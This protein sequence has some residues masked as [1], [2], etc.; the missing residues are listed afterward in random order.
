MEFLIAASLS[1]GHTGPVNN[2]LDMYR[3]GDPYLAFSKSVG[4]VPQT[5]TKKSHEAVRDKYKI[6]LLAVAVRNCRRK[7]WPAGSVSRR[8]KHT[9]CSPSITSNSRSI[10][11]GLTIGYSTRCRPVGCAQPSAGPVAPASL[12]STNGRSVTGQS[13]RPAPTFCGSACILAARHGIKLLAPVHDAVLIEAPIERIEADVAVMREIMR[14]ASRIVLN[15]NHDGTHELRT[16]YTIVRYPDRYSDKR[17][18]QIWDKV[19]QLLNDY[20]QTVGR[21]VA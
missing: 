15:A 3:S 2:M 19:L 12:N 17:G 13:R 1:D 6:M 16:D 7:H 18:V 5:A 9:K 8:L 10:G 11:P 21:K 14:R 4:A 20:Q